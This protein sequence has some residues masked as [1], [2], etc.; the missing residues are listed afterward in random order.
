V[1]KARGK[2]SGTLQPVT[3]TLRFETAMKDVVKGG[4]TVELSWSS[5]AEGKVRLTL[6]RDGK[7]SVMKED[8]PSTGTFSWIVPKLD[9]KNCQLV[10]EQGAEK[11]PSRTFTIKSSPPEIKDAEIE[12]PLRR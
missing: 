11:T 3:G 6:V 10:L 1:I 4:T 5:S 12:V 8:L 9:A 2:G 7:S